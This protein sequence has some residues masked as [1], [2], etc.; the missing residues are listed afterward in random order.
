MNN[1]FEAVNTKFKKLYELNDNFKER[2]RNEINDFY[3]LSD[4]ISAWLEAPTKNELIYWIQE[5]NIYLKT[6]KDSSISYVENTKDTNKLISTF[7]LAKIDKNLN[8]HITKE[9]ENLRFLGHEKEQ[10]DLFVAELSDSDLRP[11]KLGK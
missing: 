10:V 5:P 9:K 1:I 2:M 11:Y 4:F 3:N 8:I 7:V 6:N